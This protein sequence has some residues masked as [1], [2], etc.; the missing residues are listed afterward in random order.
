M[1]LLGMIIAVPVAAVVY[2]LIVVWK[3]KTLSD[4]NISWEM[5]ANSPD[6]QHFN[7]EED[8]LNR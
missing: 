5:Y 2:T 1:G 8:F 7:P 3:N 6:W 4:K